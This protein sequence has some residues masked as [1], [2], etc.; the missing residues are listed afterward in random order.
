MHAPHPTRPLFI[1][2]GGGHAL[3]VAEAALLSRAF[4]LAGC[5]DDASEPTLRRKL[6][7]HPVAPL[8]HAAAF[9]REHDGA[10]I[11]GLGDLRARRLLLGDL[12]ADTGV[13]L[14]AAAVVHPAAVISPSAAIG[15]G[16]FVGP[17]AIVHSF[18]VVSPH[19]IANSGSII[20][21]ECI[22]GEN[23]HAG[24]GSSLCGR[25]WAGPDALVGAGARVLPGVR[26]GKG[27]TL[28]AG[29]VA[30]KDVPAGGLAVGVP[31]RPPS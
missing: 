25:A 24:P 27:A 7:V 10:W 5:F 12:I 15:P 16:A 29:A 6:G 4:H 31:A 19:A 26:I 30:A 21:H 3:V 17:G 20:E 13:W 14:R 18:A 11:L 22:L 23:A 9:L 28:G 8:A 2:G 1:L